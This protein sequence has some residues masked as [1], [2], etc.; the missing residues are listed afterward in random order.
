MPVPIECTQ[1]RFD[2]LN[3]L[4]IAGCLNGFSFESSSGGLVKVFVSQV[5]E[6]SSNERVFSWW[7]VE[8]VSFGFS[9]KCLVQQQVGGK[10]RKVW[11]LL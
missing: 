4:F 5:S 6:L 8:A 2:K 7:F 9:S 11:F 1:T 10:P 3:Q